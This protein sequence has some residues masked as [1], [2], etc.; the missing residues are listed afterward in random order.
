MRFPIGNHPRSECPTLFYVDC[1]VMV[2]M[3]N[4]TTT[5]TAML[6][7][8][9][10]LAHSGAAFRVILRRNGYKLLVFLLV[11]AACT[12]RP[13]YLGTKIAPGVKPITEIQLERTVCYGTCPAYKVRLRRDATSTYVGEAHVSRLGT[14]HGQVGRYYF[15]R[16]AE[17]IE[18]QGVFKMKDRYPDDG[19]MIVDAPNAIINETEA[20]VPFLLARYR[21]TGIASVAS[22]R[23]G[24]LVIRSHL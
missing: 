20:E 21:Q 22:C 13:H 11:C 14:Y 10:S 5:H 15:D 4:K 19:T 2:S 8:C 6:S 16:L 7:P 18:A 12:S 17:L 23:C 24:E 1:R 9:Q 3:R